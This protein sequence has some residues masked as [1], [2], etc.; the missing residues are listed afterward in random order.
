MLVI[1]QTEAPLMVKP[2]LPMMT[3]SELHAIMTGGFATVAG[4]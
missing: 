2:Y 3:K 4:K 1:I